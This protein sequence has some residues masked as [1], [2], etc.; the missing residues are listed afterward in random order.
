MIKSSEIADLLL[1]VRPGYTLPRELYTS[2]SAFIFDTQAVLKSVW[3]YA[4]T[5][6]HVKKPGDWYVFELANNSVIIVRGKDGEIRAFHNTCTHRGARIC[7]SFKGNNARLSCPYHFWSFGLDGRLLSARGMPESFR[8]AEH[9]LRPVALENLGGL[10]FICLSDSPPPIDRAKADI[11]QQLALYDLDRLKVAEQCD[12]IDDANWKLVME[13]N[14]E[15]HHCES[16]HFELL[17]SL[18]GSG[19][20]RDFPEDKDGGGETAAKAATSAQRERWRQLGIYQDLIEFPD[21]WW[22]RIARLSLAKGAVSQTM[23]GKPAC[24]KLIWPH[25]DKEETSLS[26]WT[27]PN[28]WHHFCCDH[29]V[30][31]SL[32][33]LTEDK[34]LVRTSWLVHEDAEESVDYDLGNLTSV[35][36][37]TNYQD[38]RLAEFNHAGIRSDGYRPGLYSEEERLVEAFKSFYVNTA[39]ASLANA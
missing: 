23:D 31:F 4:C 10:L 30:T 26:I 3:L 6:A 37:A 34:T 39:K 17:N 32:V 35:W 9:G 33:P 27:Q 22:H 2:E 16:N 25:G 24:K 36:K 5:V 29:V 11:A 12:L 13:N 14:R 28:S 1:Q 21:G 38:R 15:C 20:G 18:D 8:K 19:F 7:N